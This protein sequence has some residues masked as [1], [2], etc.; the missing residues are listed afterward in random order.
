MLNLLIPLISYPYL[1]R[2]LGKETY[3]LVI[4][5]Q[6]I[7]GYLLILVGFGFE[8]SAT[9]E[10][11]IYRNNKEKL[12]EIVSSVLIIKSGLFVLALLILA[13]PLYFIPQAKGYESLF[14]LTM[15]MCLYD[16]IFPLWYFQGIEKMK[17]IT[18]I[19]L[20]SRLFFVGMI[21]ILIK[22]SSDYLLLP[23]I[24]GFGA[25]IAGSISLFIIFKKHEVDFKFQSMERIKYYLK[26]SIPIFISNVSIRLYVSTNKVIIGSFLG[27]A[28]LAYYDLG[29]KITSILKIPQSILSQTLFPKINKDKNISFVKKAFKISVTINF[30]LVIVTIV[31][32][33][34]IVLL[35]A[36]KEMLPAIWIINILALSVPIIAMSN[37]F[38]VQLLIPF[39]KIKL[40]SKIIISSG[41]IYLFQL[42]LIW[43]VW[44]INIYSLVVITVTTEIVV[45]AIMFHFCKKN[46][47]W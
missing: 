18:Y 26:D 10:I 25:L 30:L 21:F 13:I 11:S 8:I 15:W 28:D 46:K 3:G 36:G 34:N 19:T 20:V 39:G 1:I 7:I 40:F 5:A 27:M 41:A 45:T 31:F 16:F 44:S 22:S 42:L 33:K 35:L 37:I 24:N 4:F 9:K 2:V 38:G 17:Y 29:E 23:I 32:S 43:L 12:S 47:L 6:A 14:L